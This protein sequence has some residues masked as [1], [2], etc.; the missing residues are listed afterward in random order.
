LQGAIGSLGSIAGILGPLLFTQTLAAVAQAQVHTF[1]AGIT[2]WLA[3]AMVG[4]GGIVAWRVT[5]TE[6]DAPAPVVQQG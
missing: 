5:R 6:W 1:W 3:A 4:I 2:F